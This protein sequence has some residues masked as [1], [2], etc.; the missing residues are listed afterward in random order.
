MHELLVQLQP[1]IVSILVTI[2]AAFSGWLSI[3]VK[4]ILDT[5][6]K[7]EIVGATVMYVEQVGKSLG[8]EEK[9]ELAK[10]KALEWINSKGFKVTTIELEILI[11]AAVQNFYA[12]SKGAE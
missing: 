4:S 11:E 10:E 3:Q 8:S 2:I 1:Q 7:R 5:K 12:H 6:E 9:L